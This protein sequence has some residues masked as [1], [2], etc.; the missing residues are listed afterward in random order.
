MASS[1]QLRK[2]ILAVSLKGDRRQDE[3]IGGEPS[4]VK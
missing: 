2:D 1:V 4:V 3:L